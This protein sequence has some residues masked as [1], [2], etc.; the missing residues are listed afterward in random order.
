MANN[1][2]GWF[3]VSFCSALLCFAGLWIYHP[4]GPKNP[5][6]WMSSHFAEHKEEPYFT[7]HSYP[8]VFQVNGQTY[9][10][11]ICVKHG[12]IRPMLYTTSVTIK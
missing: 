9:A 8:F 5:H 1:I 2:K 4:G 12:E 7:G 6:D 3:L 11:D 10:F